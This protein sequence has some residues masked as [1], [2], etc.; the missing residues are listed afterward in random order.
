ML[1]ESNGSFYLLA[2]YFITENADQ[3][4][5]NNVEDSYLKH[6]TDGRKPS[7]TL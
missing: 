3:R 7:L 6:Q 4:A 1:R 2:I 5:L